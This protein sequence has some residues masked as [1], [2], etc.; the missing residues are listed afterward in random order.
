MDGF[1]PNPAPN[2]LLDALEV[3]GGSVGTDP[4]VGTRRTETRVGTA[5]QKGAG[6]CLSIVR[7]PS[8][9]AISIRVDVSRGGCVRGLGCDALQRFSWERKSTAWDARIADSGAPMS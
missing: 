1:R 7:A 2:R 9:A 6:S 5:E 3:L 8:R 4:V